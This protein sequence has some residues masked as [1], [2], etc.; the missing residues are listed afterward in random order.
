MDCPFRAI[1]DGFMSGAASFGKGGQSRLDAIIRSNP[2]APVSAQW[3]AHLEGVSEGPFSMLEIR[4]L[5]RI[6]RI[7]AKTSV[8]RVGSSS[9]HPAAEDELL[10]PHFSVAAVVDAG[11]APAKTFTRPRHVVVDQHIDLAEV[12]RQQGLSISGLYAGFWIRLFS[13]IID[14]IILFF[15]IILTVA[16]F[17]AVFS[18]FFENQRLFRSCL[19]ISQYMAVLFY[20]SVF[21]TG[22]WQATPGKRLLGIYIRREDGGA[23]TTVQSM[24]RYFAYTLSFLFFF[25]GFIMIAFDKEKRGLHDILAKTRVVYGKL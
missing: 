17:L 23:P 7:D 8:N 15:V 10:A 13:Y 6:S 11:Y 4:E 25:L 24:G 14:T 20:F 12:L 9:W 21:Q 16:V 19:E 18:G 2:A 3:Y 22:R 5:I 1:R